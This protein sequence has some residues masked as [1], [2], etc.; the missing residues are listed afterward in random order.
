MQILLG[1]LWGIMAQVVMFIQI[2]GQF[3]FEWLKHNVWFTILMGLPISFMI[4]Q[5]VRNFVE[6]FDG[7]IW[8]SRLIGFG[9]GVFVFSIMAHFMFREPFTLKT[10]VCLLL[11]L[12]III[13]QI[14]WK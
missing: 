11:G 14:F 7:Q 5:S 2:Q 3:K 9:I 13:I 8:P 10:G 4:I 6:A 12:G 1:I